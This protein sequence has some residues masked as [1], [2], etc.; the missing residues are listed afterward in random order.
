MC[1]SGQLSPLFICFWIVL[2]CK[3]LLELGSVAH[4][5]IS[6]LK[7]LRQEEQSWQSAPRCIMS[8]CLKQEG[9]EV[10]P[11]C[12]GP[13]A[14]APAQPDKHRSQPSSK[15]L[16]SCRWRLLQRSTAGQNA[17]DKWLWWCPAPAGTFTQQP[18]HLRLRNITDERVERP[19]VPEDQDTSLMSHLLDEAGCWT[20]EF[21]LFIFFKKRALGDIL[22]KCLPWKCDGLSLVPKTCVEKL[23]VAIHACS[24]AVRK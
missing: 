21:Y 2:V 19:G 11:D 5:V 15:K 6:E 13:A 3:E 20:H 8:H 17:E 7:R 23:G 24:T 22:V 14:C 12:A 18:L 10:L 9:M 16:P 1:H 4:T